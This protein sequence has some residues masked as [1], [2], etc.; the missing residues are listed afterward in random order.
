MTYSNEFLDAAEML[1]A[2]SDK[3][4]KKHPLTRQAMDRVMALAP[5]KLQEAMRAKAAELGL[6]PP[7]GGYLD[8][9]T[10]VYRLQDVARQMGMSEAEAQRSIARFMQEREAAGLPSGSIDPAH[11]RPLQ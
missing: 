11:V 6:I 10:Q 7:A 1:A 3:F 8:D 5:P 9:G 4:G 2:H